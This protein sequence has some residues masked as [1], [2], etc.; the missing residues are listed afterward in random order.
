MSDGPPDW[1]DVP[2]ADMSSYG[3]AAP[4]GGGN[5]GAQRGGGGRSNAPPAMTPEQL[6]QASGDFYDWLGNPETLKQLKIVLPEHVDI[7]VFVATAKTAVLNK[8]Q[9]LRENLRQSLLV[10][11]MKA[12]S[13]G[14]LPDGKQGALVP[15]YD[16]DAGG[17]IVA[18]QPMVQGIIKLG[19]ETG[20][21]KTIR[22]AIV[23]RGEH[24]RV[25]AGEDD[26]IE[27]EVDLD[28]VDEA[29]AALN[30][31][32]DNH[33]NPI[34]KPAEF[35]ARVRA[36]YCFITAPDGTVTKRY[37]THQR[38]VSLW[39][40]SKAKNGP[41]N[42][43]WV[44]EMILKGVTLFTAKWINLDSETVTAKRFQAALM[45]DMEVDFDRQGQIAAPANQD[46]PSQAAL[47]PPADKLGSLE[48][49]IMGKT[50]VR[51]KVP[52]GDPE[53]EPSPSQSTAPG[54]Q[55]GGSDRPPPPD[56]KPQEQPQTAGPAENGRSS[57]QQQPQQP[58]AD[59]PFIDRA[60]AALA[61]ES[62]PGRWLALLTATML[63]CPTMDDLAAM[64][65]VPSVVLAEK[66]APPHIR[67]QIAG[68]FTQAALRLGN[69]E[70]QE[71]SD[72]AEDDDSDGWPGPKV[73]ETV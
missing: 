35:F 62:N 65:K 13:Q 20:A 19:R 69:T 12:A 2:P 46:R 24:F 59:V 15:R 47:P 54:A 41:W 38:L 72:S 39:E 31:G 32:K 63:D 9:L 70:E 4:T 57:T 29:Y 44:D 71:P 64:K 60:A 11:I 18:W 50:R 73:G 8:P 49:A 55:G 21:I 37:M 14:L 66:S 33:G 30:G 6:A 3:Q 27:H 61:A 52:V 48:D 40:T 45:T 17:Y 56:T 25:L 28:I 51:E 1:G 58:S 67:S 23:F 7:D 26:R 68:M 22:A 42:S 53:R 5:R 10:A 16:G 34:A 43:R 36:A